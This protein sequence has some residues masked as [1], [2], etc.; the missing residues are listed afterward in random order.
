MAVGA[1]YGP[2]S[3]DGL[4]KFLPLMIH[5]LGTY[6]YS[7]TGAPSRGCY[8]HLPRSQLAWRAT[9]EQPLSTSDDRDLHHLLACGA[10]GEDIPRFVRLNP[11]LAVYG[12]DADLVLTGPGIHPDVFPERPDDG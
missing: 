10:V 5:R 8:I 9:R 11:T 4:I 12:A 3:A 7:W 6:G 2:P 1:T